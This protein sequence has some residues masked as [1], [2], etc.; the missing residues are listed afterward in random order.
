MSLTQQIGNVNINETRHMPPP[1]SGNG[2]VNDIYRWLADGGSA[3]RVKKANQRDWMSVFAKASSEGNK[4]AMRQAAGRVVGFDVP[5]RGGYAAHYRNLSSLGALYFDNGMYQDAYQIHIDIA[6][7]CQDI[8]DMQ[9]TPDSL[10]QTGDS[11]PAS[12]MKPQ[13]TTDQELELHQSGDVN[14]S[15][16][17]NRSNQLDKQPS[18][19]DVAESAPTRSG[20]QLLSHIEYGYSDSHDDFAATREVESPK[21]VVN[22]LK[23]TKSRPAAQRSVKKQYA[24]IAARKGTKPAWEEAVEEEPD[25]MLDM[26]EVFVIQGAA[27]TN[28]DRLLFSP[29]V[30]QIAKRP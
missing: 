13:S 30:S 9:P 25:S 3:L 5:E 29:K 6:Q 26:D 4:I 17:C 28:E 8:D 11:P 10:G 27:F 21:A 19:R 12:S 7:F 2:S 20:R 23:A 22:P 16:E 18:D 14:D 24:A 1:V 15:D